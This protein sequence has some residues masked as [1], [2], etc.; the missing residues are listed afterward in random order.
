MTNPV[1]K[2]SIG[3][4]THGLLGATLTLGDREIEHDGYVPDGLGIGEGGSDEIELEIDI[5]TGRIIGWDAAKVIARFDEIFAQVNTGETVDLCEILDNEDDDDEDKAEKALQRASLN[6]VFTVQS[7]EEIEAH[8]V[9]L[10]YLGLYQVSERGADALKELGIDLPFL[11]EEGISYEASQ[12]GVKLEEP[13]HGMF[14]HKASGFHPKA[15]PLLLI[16]ATAKDVA[17]I[18][19]WIA[20]NS[21]DVFARYT[22]V[23][24]QSNIGLPQSMTFA[25]EEARTA[26]IAAVQG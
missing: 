1:R 9:G 13:F 5:N 16:D 4:P 23:V 19:Q 6:E 18:N 10:F 25:T 3:A 8:Y 12:F 15:Q 2:M 17:N 26:F 21:N 11:I 20:D 7:E 14:N 24:A 22:D